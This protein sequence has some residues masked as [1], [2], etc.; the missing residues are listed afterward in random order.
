MPAVIEIDSRQSVDQSR[1]S[2]PE[3][4]PSQVDPDN[5]RKTIDLGRCGI[6][7][8]V[9]VLDEQIIYVSSDG[10]TVGIRQYLLGHHG[11][12]LLRLARRHQGWQGNE[13]IREFYRLR[14]KFGDGTEMISTREIDISEKPSPIS[15]DRWG[16]PITV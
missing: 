10:N 8:E 2:I 15:C 3:A 6:P 16:R 9:R 5:F 14:M 1:S 11:S 4:T 13:T 7:Y 12:A